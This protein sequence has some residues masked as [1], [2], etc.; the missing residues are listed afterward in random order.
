MQT[1]SQNNRYTRKHPDY[2]QRARWHDYRSR[3]I[4]MITLMKN[5]DIPTFA[6]IHPSPTSGKIQAYSANLPIGYL[7][8]KCLTIWLND[9][10]SIRLL[11]KIIMPDHIHLLLF[12]TEVIP[13]VL[14]SYLRHFKSLCTREYR[15]LLTLQN[16]S[17][18][19]LF[20]P[21][22]ND[23]IVIR[24]NQRQNFYNYISDNPL[25]YL[26]RR[27]YPEY[28]RRSLQIE[29]YSKKYSAYG[30][31][32]LL[33]HPHKSAV[34]ISRT[35]TTE[36]LTARRQKWDEIIR[37]GGVLVSPFISQAEK[38]IRDK[39]IFSGASLIIITDNGFPERYKPTGQLF[40]LCKEG[41]LLLI[42]P[43][44]YSTRHSELTRRQALEANSLAEEIAIFPIPIST[45]NP[46]KP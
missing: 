5:P 38:E 25:R 1:P 10:P 19:S 37:S 15:N 39:A 3:C 46:H 42:G 8:E 45:G 29:I 36:D 22:F 6:E 27:E 31:L 32:F 21:G 30:N 26:A 33:T 24:K 34:R 44:E 2:L 14:G 13:V 7:I 28:F 20:T 9:N 40:D 11:N 17:N 12:V 23:K 18:L 35:F 4:Y 16:K 41:R 43:A